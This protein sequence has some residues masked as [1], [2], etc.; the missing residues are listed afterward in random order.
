MSQ[1][2]HHKYEDDRI[3]VELVASTED[4]ANDGELRKALSKII[5]CA[6]S[7]DHFSLKVEIKE[8]EREQ[9]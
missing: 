5:Y 1:T 8:F 7:W 2:V 3:T 9:F 6:T 4:W